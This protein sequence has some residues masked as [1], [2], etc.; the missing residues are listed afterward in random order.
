MSTF[1]IIILL[2]L[3]CIA[4]LLGLAVYF[5]TKVFR[6]FNQKELKEEEGKSEVS[7]KSDVS[8]NI[9]SQSQIVD[10]NEIARVYMK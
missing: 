3:L 6:K 8:M 1:E 10:K 4:I 2:L 9:S 7:A 5:L